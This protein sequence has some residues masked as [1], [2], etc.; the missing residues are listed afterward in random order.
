M[1]EFVQDI[2]VLAINHAPPNPRNDVVH[3]TRVEAESDNEQF[4]GKTTV[5]KSTGCRGDCPHQ[6]GRCLE[7]AGMVMHELAVG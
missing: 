4:D 6:G 7:P 5:N 3:H 2:E 1:K